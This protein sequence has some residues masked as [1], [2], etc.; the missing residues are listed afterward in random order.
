M[1]TVLY[2]AA[3]YIS[4][5]CSYSTIDACVLCTLLNQTVKVA[6]PAQS[7]KCLLVQHIMQIKQ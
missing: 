2:I 1:N 6:T 4:F 7:L 3:A 5:K